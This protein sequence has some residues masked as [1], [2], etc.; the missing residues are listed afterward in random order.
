MFRSPAAAPSRGKL[1][2]ADSGNPHASAAHIWVGLE[3]QPPSVKQ[4]YD[5]QNYVKPYQFWVKT[6]AD[7]SFRIPHVIAGS[8]Y[9]LWAFGGAAGTFLSQDQNGGAAP[10]ELDVPDK[11]FAVTVTA[12]APTDLGNVTWTPVRVGP[13]VF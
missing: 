8:N 9:T 5:F 11:P 3:Q 13:T 10:L 7:G 2:I 12:G 6:D 1:V 4:V